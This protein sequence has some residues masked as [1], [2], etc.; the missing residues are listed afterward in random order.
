MQLLLEYRWP[1]Q[2]I[3]QGTDLPQIGASGTAGMHLLLLL[4]LLLLQ[5]LLLM[6]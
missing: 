6:K 5:A 4:L 3:C 1:W 2:M